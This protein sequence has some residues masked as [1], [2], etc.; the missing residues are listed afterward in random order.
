MEDLPTCSCALSA[1]VTEMQT[2]LSTHTWNV[3]DWQYALRVPSSEIH[4]RAAE[5]ELM[6]N[7]MD[8]SDESQFVLTELYLAI[9]ESTR[10]GEGKCRRCVSE[11]LALVWQACR[12]LHSVHSML[13][14]SPQYAS[15]RAVIIDAV[16]C[17]EVKLNLLHTANAK[18]AAATADMGPDDVLPLFSFTLV[19]SG[20]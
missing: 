16:H 19:G 20:R 17:I 5:M 8:M 6:C 14:A 10:G 2:M 3:V 11:A 9:D 1:S 12:W 7:I 15:L 13:R 18:H 4:I